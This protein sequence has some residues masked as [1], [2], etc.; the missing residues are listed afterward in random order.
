MVLGKEEER[1]K[2][3]LWC[4]HDNS[5]TEPSWVEDS[6]GVVLYP[7]VAAAKRDIKENFVSQNYIIKE[8]RP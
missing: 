7:S 1:I 8:Y 3:G 2:Y 6:K 5:P 4:A